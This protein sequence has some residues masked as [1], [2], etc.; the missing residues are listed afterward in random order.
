MKVT[1]YTNELYEDLCSWLEARKIK[2]WEKDFIP[3]IGYVASYRDAPVAV[4]FL[5]QVEGDVYW[6]DGLCSNPM[7]SAVTRNDAI[8]A[9]VAA[10]IARAKELKLRG[11]VALCKDSNTISRGQRFGFTIRDDKMVVLNLGA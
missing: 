4:G 8:N 3:K 2:P 7:A 5:R 9:V 10:L 1:P 6:L 11:L